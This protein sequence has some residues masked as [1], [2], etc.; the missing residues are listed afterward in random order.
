MSRFQLLASAKS[1]YD[2]K[3]LTEIKQQALAFYAEV[4]YGIKHPLRS[5]LLTYCFGNEFSGMD[6]ALFFGDEAG[7]NRWILLQREHFVSAAI[8]ENEVCNPWN[9]DTIEKWNE[10]FQRGEFSHYWQARR[11]FGGFAVSTTRPYHFFYDQLINLQW[12]ADHLP[13]GIADITRGPHC[14]LDPSVALGGNVG[15]QPYNNNKFYLLPTIVGANWRRDLHPAEFYSEAS[16]LERRIHSHFPMV[17]KTKDLCVWI[18]VTGQKRSWVEQIPGYVSI[19]RRLSQIQNIQLLIDGLTSEDGR[20]GDFPEDRIIVEEIISDLPSNVSCEN[21]VGAD[22]GKKISLCKAADVF[23]TNGGTGSFVPLRICQIPGVIHYSP[24]LLAFQNDEYDGEK[25][26]FLGPNYVKDVVHPEFTR[27]DFRS[28]HLHWQ[29]IY[30]EIIRVCEKLYGQE[31]VPNPKDSFPQ[32]DLERLGSLH[33]YLKGGVK[34]ADILLDLSL[35]F[36]QRGD[37]DTALALAKQA[38]IQRQGTRRDAVNAVIRLRSLLP[39]ASDT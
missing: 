11:P 23:V 7:E 20:S 8:T 35:F 6:N 4:A 24:G 33:G 18:G 13:A 19:V 34:V 12:F 15:C 3:N 29:Y 27:G 30:N 9:L 28:Y 21:L 37:V 32:S 25:Y 16:K 1:A 26:T 36:E 2:Q 22:Y 14:Y 17:E 38:V 39:R 31:L 5:E 10:K